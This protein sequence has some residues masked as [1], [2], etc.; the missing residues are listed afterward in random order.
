MPDKFKLD[1]LQLVACLP[2]IY[3]PGIM[4]TNTSPTSPGS[5]YLNYTETRNYLLV[6]TLFQI[7]FDGIWTL[8]GDWSR[9]LFPAENNY[10][11]HERQCLTIV[12][13]INTLHPYLLYNKFTVYTYHSALHWLMDITGPSARLTRLHLHSMETFRKYR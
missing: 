2:H 4:A 13:A 5:P 3:T 10:G 9:S 7:C 11:A 1:E 6:E 8:I 12:W